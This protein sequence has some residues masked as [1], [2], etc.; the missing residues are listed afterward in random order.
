MRYNM[1]PSYSGLIKDLL[2]LYQQDPK[3]FMRFYNS[4]YLKLLNIPEGG[5][6][7]LADH[8]SQR[9]M[10]VF[11]KIASL[12]IIEDLCQKEATDDFLEFSDDHTAIRR[13]RKFVPSRPYR[14]GR[15]GI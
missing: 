15:K 12:F 8:C 5:V 4:I 7:R 14:K 9:A 3:R 6:L 10:E 2:P 13:C 1:A 11:I